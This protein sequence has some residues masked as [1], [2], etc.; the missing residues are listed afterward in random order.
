MEKT[1]LNNVELLAQILILFSFILFS[2]AVIFVIVTTFVKSKRVS[3]NK[4]VFVFTIANAISIWCLQFIADYVNTDC[5]A[6]TWFELLAFSFYHTLKAF[7]A[8]DS[9]LMGIQDMITLI[10]ANNFFEYRLFSSIL[11]I[12]APITSAT[13][14]FEILSN[15]FPKIKLY[16]FNICFFKKKYFF[17]KLNV[18]SI[19]LAK[20][21][22]D[23]EKGLSP[24][25][26]FSDV[27]EDKTE[28]NTSE[29]F[30]QA[31]NIGAICLRDDIMH[32]QKTGLG[33]R[34][35]FL[36]DDNEISNLQ[37]FVKLTEK[38]NQISLKNSGIYLF[39][40]DYIYADVENQV[41]E[42]Y[43]KDNGNKD[44]LPFAPVRHY[45]NLIA[46]MLEETPLYEP[47]VHQRNK[48]P[49]AILDLNITILGIGDIGRE[50]FLT[51]YWMGQMLNCRLN[52]TVIS[53]EPEEEF[54]GKIDRINPEIKQTIQ[55]GDNPAYNEA[56]RVYTDDK[57]DENGNPLADELKFSE[58]YAKVKYISCDVQSDKFMELFDSA[59]SDTALLDT[60][61]FLISL[62]SDQMNLSV[63][64]IL[65]KTIGQ[66]HLEN[67]TNADGCDKKTIINYVVYNTA[68]NNVLNTNKFVCSYD[69]D[70]PDIFMQAVGGVEQ[71]FSAENIFMSKYREESSNEDMKIGEYVNWSNL[72]L[73]LHFKYKVFSAKLIDR[74]IFDGEAEHAKNTNNAFDTYIKLA[75]RELKE[76]YSFEQEMEFQNNMQW[77]EHRRWCAFLRIMGYRYT[78]DYKN[79]ISATQSHKQ[80]ELKLH[81][82]LIE[83]DKN[84]IHGSLDENGKV[85]KSLITKESDGNIKINATDDEILGFD[86][87]DQ[88]SC[89]LADVARCD[90]KKYDY[91]NNPYLET[92][93][94]N[95]EG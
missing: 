76:N 48:N 80:M 69:N 67:K 74:S 32:I 5:P 10:P 66:Y 94:I 31:K 59:N 91:P 2:S 75:R 23:T 12:C 53:K 1:F 17:S 62:G 24:V 63:A 18:Q 19:A 81:P 87:L 34:K 3:F 82:C 44:K 21:I 30:A 89:D 70:E 55:I 85:I 42:N 84:G 56:L 15:F 50:M 92:I 58:P 90:F 11:A 40:Q 72:A 20:S 25:I 16:I 38:S 22:L 47:I 46:N 37:T 29:L 41:A 33:E 52:I 45:R 93:K 65:K 8:E 79:Y 68:L 88:L 57:K 60:H 39:C 43:E 49:D 13:I 26:I 86:L 14:L 78:K 27:Y 35:Y 83:C 61:Y 4:R 9:F 36:I 7:G 95:K 28:E 54:W 73:R 71:F 6:D 51:T 77:L 64:N